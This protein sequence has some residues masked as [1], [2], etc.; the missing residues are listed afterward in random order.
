MGIFKYTFLHKLLNEPSFQDSK[1]IQLNISTTLKL[2]VQFPLII[3]FTFGSIRVEC[4]RSFLGESMLRKR[5]RHRSSIPN[6]N[7]LTNGQGLNMQTMAIEINDSNV[8]TGPDKIK[9]S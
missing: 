4:P 6:L 3:L 5:L 1:N 2:G 8:N 7:E 9:D